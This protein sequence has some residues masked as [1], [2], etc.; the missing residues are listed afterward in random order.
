L[1][2]RE[3]SWGRAQR[4]RCWQVTAHGFLSTRRG[5]D[6]GVRTGQTK[7]SGTEDDLSLRFL[8]PLSDPHG[9][10]LA[11]QRLGQRL[12]RQ[13]RAISGALGAL[14]LISLGAGGAVLPRLLPK[15]AP[16]VPRTG[17]VPPRTTLCRQP[18][19]TAN[20]VCFVAGTPVLVWD[21][22]DLELA[23]Q[24]MAPVGWSYGHWAGAG[25]AVIV[26][27]IGWQ[28]VGDRQRRRWQCK[29]ADETE[30]AEIEDATGIDSNDK[31]TWEKATIRATASSDS[32]HKHPSNQV[33]KTVRRRSAQ[34]WKSAVM[35]QT[36]AP[37]APRSAAAQATACI[38]MRPRRTSARQEANAH[39]ASRLGHSWL[40]VWLLVAA[41]LVG[42][43]L[44]LVDPSPPAPGMRLG[45]RPAVPLVPEQA[46]PPGI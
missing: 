9:E 31:R 11:G 41:A 10:S 4:P 1:S 18:C 17:K 6:K 27:V 37:E 34:V 43:A 36:H 21:E 32:W 35:G 16:R 7:V 19:N 42:H 8:T 39:R 3:R 25:A 12:S 15:Q 46:F 38:P 30:L 22:E 2:E 33:P 13:E 14:E 29:A 40:A 26:G 28:C 45:D 20:G 24:V 5:S 23:T 44:Q